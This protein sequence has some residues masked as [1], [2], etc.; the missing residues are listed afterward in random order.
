[1]TLRNQS[2][3]IVVD[4]LSGDSRQRAYK[5]RMVL[6]TDAVEKVGGVEGFPSE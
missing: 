1:L 2:E 4:P 5:A 3:N 6:M